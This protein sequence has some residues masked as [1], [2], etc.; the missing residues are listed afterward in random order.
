MFV[1]PYKCALFIFIHSYVCS[2]TRY[3][4]SVIRTKPTNDG[5]LIMCEHW[6]DISRLKGSLYSKRV[7]DRCYKI[8]GFALFGP[9]STKLINKYYI[10]CALNKRKRN[11]C[12]QFNLINTQSLCSQTVTK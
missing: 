6:P 1:D 10:Y 12:H 4:K 11:P 2:M 7:L 3:K 9:L 5:E 8:S